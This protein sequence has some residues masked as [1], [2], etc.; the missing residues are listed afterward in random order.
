[1]TVNVYRRQDGSVGIRNYLLVMA[2]T[3]AVHYVAASIAGLTEGTKCFV[4]Q[5]EDGKSLRDRQTLRRVIVGLGSNP[6]VGG[7]LLICN[8]KSQGYPELIPAELAAEIKKTG[9]PV[10]LLCL[11][12]AG[13]MYEALAAG[14]RIARR[15]SREISYYRRTEASLGDLCLGIK[16]G[17]SDA[18]SGIAG[19]PVAGGVFDLFVEQGGTAF[20]SETT[21]VIGA[22]HLLAK[23]CADDEVRKKLLNAVREAEESALSTGEDIR[24]INPIPA[25]IAAGITTLEEKSLGAVSKAGSSVIR[26]V[27]SYGERPK[28]RG[29]FFVDS[30][31]SSTSLFLG[32]AAAGAVLV[33][34]QMGGME[35]PRSFVSPAFATGIVAPILYMTGNPRTYEKAPDEIDFNAGTVI[36]EGALVESAARDLEALICRT[37]AGGMVKSETLRYQDQAEIYFRGPNL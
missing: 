17:L 7:V 25:N 4:P 36:S 27:L 2:A 37:A 11:D 19:N 22:E 28:G 33:I 34:F 3:R 5:D 9:K 29:L 13:G 30:W 12:E 8:G 18:T 16:C 23:R 26:G 6:N 10:E 20:F 1:M 31:M 32:Y 24:T 21:E 15:L 35:L 14:L